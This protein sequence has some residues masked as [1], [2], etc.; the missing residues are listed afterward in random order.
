MSES[1]TP[2]VGADTAWMLVATALVLLMTPGLAFFYGGLVRSKNA[3][4]TMMM[5]IASLGVVGILWTVLGYSLAFGRGNAAL[6]GLDHLLLRG[7]AFLLLVAVLWVLTDELDL[8]NV[9]TP[10]GVGR[11][12]FGAASGVVLI[13]EFAYVDD[14]YGGENERMNTIFKAYIQAWILLG[15]A[16]AGLSAGIVAA[17]RERRWPWKAGFAAA[18]VALLVAGSCFPLFADYSRSQRFRQTRSGNTPTYD[19][20][21]LFHKELSY[22]ARA[23]E[24]VEANLPKDAVLVEAS[25]HAYEWESRFA[26]FT[27]RIGLVGWQNHES[28]WRNSWKDSLER[29]EVLKVV[30]AGDSAAKAAE[31]LAPYGVQYLVVGE[32]ERDRRKY[33]AYKLEKFE[34]WERV[35]ASDRVVIYRVPAINP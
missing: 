31:A 14:F 6:G 26:S 18:G 13:C 35:Y 9:R 20:L 1:G 17:L 5:S 24:W 12:L 4:N 8:E 11:L 3:L 10:E 25:A 34:A 28:G 27:G 19:S 23:V 2:V 32:L 33:P 7:L 22:D 30:Y 16:S 29:A 21:D 15:V